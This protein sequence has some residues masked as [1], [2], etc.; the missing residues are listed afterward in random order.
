MGR[1]YERIAYWEAET[2]NGL[3]VGTKIEE[4]QRFFSARG[5][6]LG[7]CVS[8]PGM[9]EAHYAREA[10]VGSFGLV[11]YDVV[12]LVSSDASKQLQ[13]VQVQRWGVGL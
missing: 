10:E 3:P 5:V 9:R 1:V 4:A 2:K 7:C 13:A 11:R 12:V 8:A 6:E